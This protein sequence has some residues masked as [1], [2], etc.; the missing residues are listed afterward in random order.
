MIMYS[1]TNQLH[2]WVCRN[3]AMNMLTAPLLEW[4]LPH[5]HMRFLYKKTF[6][7]ILQRED[8]EGLLLLTPRHRA[9]HE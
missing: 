5:L 9:A 8:V 4:T 7:V 3:S 1:V 6:L 2:P